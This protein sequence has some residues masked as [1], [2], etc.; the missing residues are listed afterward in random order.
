[1]VGLHGGVCDELGEWGYVV[2]CEDD[3]AH[4]HGVYEGGAQNDSNG[5]PIPWR[6]QGYDQAEDD[7]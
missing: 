1:M 6:F 3:A 2:A 4:V 5:L 7:A